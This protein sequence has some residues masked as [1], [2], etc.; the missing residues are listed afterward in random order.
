[1][2]LEREVEH[3]VSVTNLAMAMMRA[4]NYDRTNCACGV[5]IMASVLAGQDR[6]ARTMLAQQMLKLARELDPDLVNARW[7]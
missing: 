2:S 6:D 5:A 7:Q 4:Q 3:T 1:M